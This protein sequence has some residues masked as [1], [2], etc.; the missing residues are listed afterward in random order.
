[1]TGNENLEFV[2]RVLEIE[3]GL[4][5]IVLTAYPEKNT[6]M[7]AVRIPNIAAYL[8]KYKSES[9]DL[10][11]LAG[12]TIERFRAIAQLLIA[13]G[14]LDELGVEIGHLARYLGGVRPS[15]GPVP[16]E[17]SMAI[18]VRNA[19]RGLLDVKRIAEAVAANVEDRTIEK[20]TCH[21]LQCPRLE[22]LS[23]A[24]DETIE[25]IEETKSTFHSIRLMNQR[26][27]LEKLRDE[28]R[29]WPREDSSEEPGEQD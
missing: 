20:A 10:L 9:T 27:D 5:V 19:V 12:T 26:K 25:V 4:P 14:E 18:S 2:R 17:V 23:G 8:D 11:E 6:A 13:R 3:P 22:R 1:M 28:L 24:I 21:L 15:A 7:D 16:V 29:R